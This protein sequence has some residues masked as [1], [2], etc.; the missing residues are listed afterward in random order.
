MSE[1]NP[2]GDLELTSPAATDPSAGTDAGGEP[3]ELLAGK[4]ESVEELERGYKEQSGGYQRLQD[5]LRREREEKRQ[6][7]AQRQPA[8]AEPVVDPLAGPKER[9]EEAGLSPQDIV[10]I[11]VEAA[12][13]EAVA[14]MQK[15]LAPA[16]NA[17]VAIGAVDADLQPQAQ[18]FLQDNPDVNEDY[19]RL[20][21]MDG[22][23][24]GKY[25]NS[26]LK[27][28][29]LEADAAAIDADVK[30]DRADKRK[31]AGT[32]SRRSDSR[33]SKS[34]KSDQAAREEKLK[35][36]AERA[37]RGDA[38]GYA[39]ELFDNVKPIWPGNQTLGT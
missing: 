3:A 38:R 11:T 37:S 26:V 33:A 10:D 30:A 29:A 27:L 5:D 9:L 14:E 12:R 6:L 35:G 7:L 1:D 15:Q 31:H 16:A 28:N 39:S 23:S 36:L 18:R 2:H 25:L 19:Q 20:L 21:Q 4:Y 24:A 17:A 32:I 34:T 22:Q 13:A 8:P